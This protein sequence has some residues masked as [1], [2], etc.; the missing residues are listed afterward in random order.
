MSLGNSELTNSR[1][2]VHLSCL[3]VSEQCRCLAHPVRKITVALLTSLI[4]VILERAC[5]RAERHYIGICIVL[6]EIKILDSAD[7]AR[8]VLS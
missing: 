3:L 1:K 5:H 6:D 8:T 4:Y 7:L 2:S